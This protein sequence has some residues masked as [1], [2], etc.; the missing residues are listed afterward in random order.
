[1]A[2]L[3]GP[4]VPDAAAP[5]PALVLTSGNASGEPLTWRNDDAVSRLGSIADALLVHD[6]PIERPIDDS[7]VR[8]LAMLSPGSSP[9]E[10][11]LRESFSSPSLLPDAASSWP[12]PVRRARGYVPDPVAF[13]PPAGRPI[14]ALGGDLKGA[15]CL[16]RGHQAVLGEHLGDLDNPA[17]FRNFIDAQDR[18]GRLLQISPEVIVCDRHPGYQSTAYAQRLARGG[19]DVTLSQSSVADVAPVREASPRELIEVQH[20]HAHAV[21]CMVDNGLPLVGPEARVVALCCDGTGYGDGGEIWG[22]EVLVCDATSYR[23]AAQ[24]WPAPLLGGD[25][26]ARQCWR[27]LAGLFVETFG[28]TGHAATREAMRYL[29]EVSRSVVDPMAL[30]IA[31]QRLAQRQTGFSRGVPRCSSLGR[32]FDAVASL[33][34]I[35]AENR[36]ESEAAMR[37]EAAAARALREGK[38]IIPLGGEA[39]ADALVVASEGRDVAAPRLILDS[40]VLIRDLASRVVKGETAGD[41]AAAF[42]EG[43]SRL[44][45]AAAVRVAEAEGLERV[46]LS[47]GSF[48]NRFFLTR[49]GALL[50]ESGLRVYRHRLVPSGDGGLALGQAAIANAQLIA[51]S[52]KLGA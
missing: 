15:I 9:K 12:I 24:L 49:V 17:A 21:S 47:G 1:G 3:E 36:Y 22:G 43:I 8:S 2:D 33:T 39:V 32:L 16:A 38:R 20:H 5:M 31:A 18:L 10:A 26:A 52:G 44:F 28:D 19:R 23:H 41:L 45:A 13:D 48:V 46:V 37:V 11:S 25:A 35:C 50:S 4:D 30:D 6:R 40:R 7:V 42:H 29:G 27:P 34:G 51:R 14:L